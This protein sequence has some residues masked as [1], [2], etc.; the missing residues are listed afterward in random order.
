MTWYSFLTNTS[1][2]ILND[3]PPGDDFIIGRSVTIAV[4]GS[5]AIDLN[6][7]DH[8]AE[9]YGTVVSTTGT[10][11]ELGADS[12]STS[13]GHTVNVYAG[14]FIRGFGDAGIHTF[15]YGTTINNAGNIFGKDYG[16]S[17]YFGGA[18]LTT[19]TNTGTIT[20][21]SNAVYVLDDSASVYILTNRGFIQG[22]I[23]SFFGDDGADIVNNFGTMIGEV[24]LY[25]GND[26][27][28][29]ASGH[30]SGHVLGQQGND[31]AIGG[32]DND[33]FEGG[34]DNDALYGNAGKDTLKGDDGNDTLFGGLGNDTLTGGLN[35]DYFVFN[36]KLN[37]STNR[38]VI[39]DFSHADDTFK[40]ENA[41]FT[42]LGAG[43]HGLNAAF[44]RA[45]VKAADPN[46]YIVYNKATGVLSYDSDGNGSH[47]AIAFA[48][49]PNK[50]VL[51]ANDFAVI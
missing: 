41:V 17:T 29:G 31:T 19:V 37:A 13:L 50:P 10:G 27:Y 51:A 23:R 26:M 11:I 43:V 15:G 39:T 42:K 25:P 35:N 14:A 12:A 24:I 48:Y 47:A 5:D 4:T 21:G 45:A 40:L 49:L 16:V 46:D 2:I 3:V 30:L 44:F 36:T 22:G 38:D 32:V 20:S 33:W 7:I 6:S 8:T 34:T 1:P 28:N 18:N 9:I